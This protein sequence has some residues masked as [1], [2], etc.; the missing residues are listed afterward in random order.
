M[1]TDVEQRLKFHHLHCS[2][3]HNYD[4][5]PDLS[6]LMA[7]VSSATQFNDVTQPYSVIQSGHSM[8]NNSLIYSYV[9]VLPFNSTCALQLGQYNFL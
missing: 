5:S 3:I 4:V 1:P 9:V 7:Y 8:Y 6:R 2:V